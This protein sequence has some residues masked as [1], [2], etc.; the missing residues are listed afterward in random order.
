MS[1]QV[2]APDR[3][4]VIVRTSIIGIAANVAL[5]AF[6]AAVGI[7]S[8]SI[9]VVLDAVNNLTDALS[10]VITILGAKLANRKP[11]REHPLGHGRYEYLSAMVIAAIV[12]YA[13]FTAL[14][15]SVKKII[16]PEVAD[17][18]VTALIIIAAA[19]AVKLVLGRYVQSKGEQVNSGSLIASGKDALFDAAL[20]ASVLLAALVF[21]FTGISLEAY[22]GVIISAVIIK[23]GVEM[24]KETLDDIL[25]HR[26]DSELSRGIKRTICTD[27]AVL[28]AYDLLM[29]SYGP[30]LTVGSVH[31][32]VPDTM[33]AME[34]DEMTRRIQQSVIE[35]HGVV[36]A[37][38]GIYSRNTSDDVVTEMRSEVTR[39]VMAHDGVLQMH[40]FFVNVEA[41]TVTFDLVIDFAVKNRQEL[42]CEIVDE[43]AALYPDYSFSVTLDRDFSD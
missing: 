33:T 21:I 15:E 3:E 20:S 7:L 16:E 1:D 4:K 23:A 8:N 26:P 43:V 35:E 12:L 17:Y 41:K 11:D 9:A 28:G 5:A 38:V 25:G 6:K 27:S 31:V 37:T 39:T 2:I 36:L 13:G 30:N 22:V 24:L 32:E 10:S 19:V 14:I 29:E 40:G 18:S 42:Y 34:I